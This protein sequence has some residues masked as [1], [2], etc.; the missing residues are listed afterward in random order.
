MALLA[1][2]ALVAGVVWLVWPFWRLSATFGELTEPVPSRLYGAPTVLRVGRGIAPDALVTELSELGY[3]RDAGGG[4][5]P[6]EYRIAR[7]RLAVHLRGFPRAGG[8]DEGGLLEVG[9][10]GRWIDSLRWRGR[11]VDE[12]SLEPPL[13]ASFYGDD[14]QDRWPVDLER[15]PDDLVHAVLAAEDAGFYDHPGLS[16]RGMARALWVNLRG[17]EVLQGGSTLTQQLVKNLY[18]THERTLLRKV[19]EAVLALL[20]DARY[21]KEQILRAY[22]NQIYWGRSG[23]VN[24]MGVGAASRAY[25][26]CPPERLDLGESALLAGMIRSPGSYAPGNDP[27]RTRARRDWV[28]GRMAELGWVSEEGASAASAAPL[29]AKRHRIAARG[30]PYFAQRIAAEA[31]ERYELH[32]LE[33]SGHAL[34][35]TLRAQDQTEA[36]S[37]VSWGVEALESGWEKGRAERGALEA[38]LVAI[39][40]AT[41]RILAYV[42]GRDW[43]TSQFD[44]VSR[45]RRQ[46]GSS[47]KPVVYAAALEDGRIVPSTMVQDEP[48]TVRLAGRSWSPSNDDDEF[49]GWVT[50]RTA[51]EKSLNV[52]TV[53]VAMDVGLPRIVEV[54]RAMG[55][56]SD[57]APY[58]SLALGSFE[59][60]PLELATVYAT[61]AAGGIRPPVH[62]LSA[63]LDRSGAAVDGRSPGTPSRALSARTAFLVGSILQGVLDRGTGRSVRDQGLTDH[64]AGKTG[65][66]NERRDSWFGGYSPDRISLVWVGYDDNR[67]THLSGG[68]AALPIWGRFTWKV[69]PTGGYPLPEQPAGITT[70]VIDPDTGDLATERC[71]ELFTEVFP[72]ERVPTQLCRL[73]GGWPVDEIGPDGQPR[74]R[75]PIRRWLERLFKGKKGDGEG[76]RGSGGG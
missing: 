5:D 18:L 48:L 66:T 6:G 13:L 34:L 47:F 40:P 55:I 21:S 28:L 62:G 49:R 2:T 44:R 69:R 45:A 23:A 7:A 25:F 59:V 12:A 56:T 58:P 8:W 39:E 50:A 9:F 67:A 22:L 74:N 60:T 32:D 42:G 46:P 29:P 68:R 53:R 76:R 24:L 75:R 19:R 30:V 33:T 64:L 27:E 1:L 3:R 26:G 14:L 51:V 43:G 10:V 73:H 16:A 20:L 31:G 72:V 15:L 70:A 54:A 17:G 36:E 71:P 65:T 11:V 57:I 37:A 38:A 61:L 52:P 4:F 63:V 41:G 35:S